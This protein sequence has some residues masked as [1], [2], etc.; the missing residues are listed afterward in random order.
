MDLIFATFGTNGMW[1]DLIANFGPLVGVVLF[2][3]WRDWKREDH[4]T[5]R[6]EKLEDYQRD[7][8]VGLVDKS[9]TALA[10]NAECLTWVARTTE[11]MCNRCPFVEETSTPEGMK[12]VKR[13]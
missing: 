6:I 10:Q 11:R 13:R 12:D 1:T 7:T 9:T 8:L 3:I 4:L 2:F 5:N